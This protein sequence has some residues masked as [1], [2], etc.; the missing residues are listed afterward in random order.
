M[1][2]FSLK[3]LVLLL[4]SF[5]LITGCDDDGDGDGGV[6][7]F[8][9]DYVISKAEVSESFVVSINGPVGPI[10]IPIDAG[11]DITEAIQEALL[12]QV[13]CDSADKSYV[14]LRED[15][16]MYMSCAGENELN[17]GTWE[18]VSATELKLNMNAAAIP[19]S[20]IGFSL[21]VTDIAIAGANMSGL[22]SVPLP[23]DMVEVLIAPATLAPGNPS[24][25]MVNFS[26]TFVKQ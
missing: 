7:P 14:E 20:P 1:K 22:T 13:D 6:S 18:E 21:T 10:D 17:A 5:V 11:M 12:S 26:L 25:F 16:S 15:N 8:V 4:F 23:Q 24:I 3:Y 2:N 9:G 19:I